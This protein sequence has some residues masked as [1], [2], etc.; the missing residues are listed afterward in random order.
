[1]R[2]SFFEQVNK[3]FLITVRFAVFCNMRTRS[4]ALE[5]DLLDF[6]LCCF[7]QHGKYMLPNV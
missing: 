6:F 4:P 5:L 7:S 3:L 1:M 2:G